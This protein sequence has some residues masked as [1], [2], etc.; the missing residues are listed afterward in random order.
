MNSG[1]S[2]EEKIEQTKPKDCF[3]KL[4][5][6]FI[7]KNIF[8]VLKKINYRKT[9]FRAPHLLSIPPPLI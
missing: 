4:K 6:N 8:N 1:I 3:E 7:L 5:S 2:K 9:H